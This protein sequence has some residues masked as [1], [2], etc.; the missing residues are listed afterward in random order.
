MTESGTR[1]ELF[2][3]L[4]ELAE[5]VSDMRGGQVMAAVGELCATSD[6]GFATQPMRNSLRPCGSSR[7][8]LRVRLLRTLDA[9]R[10]NKRVDQSGRWLR[11][12]TVDDQYRPPGHPGRSATNGGYRIVTPFPTDHEYNSICIPCQPVY[13]ER[14]CQVFASRREVVGMVAGVSGYVSSPT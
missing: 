12:S 3:A 10:P 7:R 11:F 8:K 9:N 2:A 13:T 5:I 1:T 4:G 6:A 14:I